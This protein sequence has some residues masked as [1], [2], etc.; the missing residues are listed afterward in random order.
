[1]NCGALSSL[2]MGGETNSLIHSSTSRK[3]IVIVKVLWNVLNALLVLRLVSLKD[4]QLVVLQDNSASSK[5]LAVS[6]V[7][8]CGQRHLL[9]ML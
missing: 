3:G 6:K 8:E 2:Y 7:I 1:M 9:F 5:N 4:Q